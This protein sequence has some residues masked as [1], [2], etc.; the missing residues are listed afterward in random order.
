MASPDC[1]EIFDAEGRWNDEFIRS[2]MMI[3]FHQRLKVIF[4]SFDGDV[5]HLSHSLM[6]EIWIAETRTIALRRR[7][8]SAAATR[9]DA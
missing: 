8:R 4:D 3:E 9:T 5:R 7:E 2:P 1:V 6:A